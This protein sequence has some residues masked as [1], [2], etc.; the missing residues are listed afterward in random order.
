MNKNS[1]EMMKKLIEEKRNK[2]NNTKNT[3]RAKKQLEA[4][5]K[6]LKEA[7]M[8]GDYFLE[9]IE[10]IM[11]IISFITPKSSA[12]LS[13][14]SIASA[15]TSVRTSLTFFILSEISG[16]SPHSLFILDLLVDIISF[17]DDIKPA[18]LRKTIII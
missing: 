16:R 12:K 3:M 13:F 5:L 6:V 17:K 15:V 1:I 9:K 14:T 10:I 2:S 4:F 7:I 18:N 11:L 8:V